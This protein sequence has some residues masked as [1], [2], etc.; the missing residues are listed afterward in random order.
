MI[1]HS[2]IEYGDLVAVVLDA[3]TACQ[4]VLLLIVLRFSFLHLE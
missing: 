1:E 2:L 4:C 3:G